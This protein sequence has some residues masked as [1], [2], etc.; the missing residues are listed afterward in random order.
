MKLVVD[1]KLL[2]EALTRLQAVADKKA[3]MPVLGHIHMFAADGAVTLSASDL[4][5]SLR[6]E[7]AASVDASG[8]VCLP[9]KELMERVRMLPNGPVG[10][11]VE[12]DTK[13]TIRAV[14]TARRYV[15]HGLPGF[16]Y[17]TLPDPT[18]PIAKLDT[19]IGKLS[20]LLKTTHFAISTDETRL[21]LNSLMLECDSFGSIRAAATD[22]HRLSAISSGK[23]IDTN[24][25]R[26]LI[27]LKGVQELKKLCEGCSE[28]DQEVSLF[29][30]GPNLFA[31]LGGYLFSVK[32][33]DQQFPPIDQVIPKSV[34]HTVS[35]DRRQMADA[36]SAVS[37]SSPDRTGGIKLTFRNGTVILSAENEESGQGTDEIDTDY[38][39]TEETYG[40]NARYVLDV[41]GACASDRMTIGLSGE[42][43]PTLFKSADDDGFLSV[44]MPMRL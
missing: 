10:I 22:G 12:G 2:F 44:I 24:A 20:L 38:V 14:G 1:R 23:P 21:H 19:T 18:S 15:M 8:S 35:F 34:N 39:G 43:D 27:P 4:I 36:L 40:F 25:Y 13:A 32:T 5:V 30:V 37:I 7:I 41:L 31:R 26:W 9:A 42:L 28:A 33:V 17:P 16:E 3:V 11:S 29:Q 6:T